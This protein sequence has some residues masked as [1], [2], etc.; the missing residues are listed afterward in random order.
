MGSHPYALYTSRAAWMGHFQDGIGASEAAAVLGV[1]PWKT[2]VQLWEEKTGAATPE[3]IG[4][5]PYVRYGNEA[6]PLLRA[7]FA[8]D[9]PEYRVSFTPWKVYHH[10]EKPYITCTPDGELE[11][12][13]TGR[14]GGLEIKTTEIMSSLEWEKWKGRV[15]TSAGTTEKPR[16]AGS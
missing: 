11:E 7:L 8:L 15:S 10:P 12:V 1:S 6:E 16:S 9:H 3:D 14:S 2:N 13:A 5:K 4:D